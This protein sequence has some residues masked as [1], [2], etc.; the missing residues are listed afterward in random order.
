MKLSKLT[1]ALVVALLA[2]ACLATTVNA[3]SNEDLKGYLTGTHTIGGKTYQLDSSDRTAIINRLNER[4]V[5]DSEAA[6]IK[7]QID[8]VKAEAEK[9]MKAQNITSIYDLNAESKAKAGA[10]LKEAAKIAG[11]EIKQGTDGG[12]TAVD[13]K[14]ESVISQKAKGSFKSIFQEVQTNATGS[15]NND[16]TNNSTTTVNKFA[17]TGSIVPVYTIV[18]LIA[19]VAVSVCLVRKVNAK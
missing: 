9:D 2:I 10:K 16:S 14:T 8:S 5:T 6:T 3:Y 12:Y 1:I 17:K 11:V 13:I 7:S 4:P 15:T 19:L 18:A